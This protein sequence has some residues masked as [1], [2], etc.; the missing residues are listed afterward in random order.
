MLDGLRE[1]LFGKPIPPGGVE[2]IPQDARD[3][4]HRLRNTSMK[5]EQ[6]KREINAEARDLL[7]LLARDIR[8]TG[9]G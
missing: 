2:C 9:A 5:M 6:A 3:A 4:H 7:A 8:R 1:F